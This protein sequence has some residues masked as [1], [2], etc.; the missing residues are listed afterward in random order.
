ML[1][2]QV[3]GAAGA[4]LIQNAL[5]FGSAKPR[6]IGF[7]LLFRPMSLG[8]LLE[9]LQVDYIRHANLRHA[10]SR[11]ATYRRRRSHRMSE[12]FLAI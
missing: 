7:G 8:A 2:Q 6:P 9:S 11:H 10:T 4:L 3:V 12:H 5:G 1:I